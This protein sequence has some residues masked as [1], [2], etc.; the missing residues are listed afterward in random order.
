MAARACTWRRRRSS[1]GLASP[2]RITQLGGAGPWRRAGDGQR[3]KTGRRDLF[4]TLLKPR[5]FFLQ[6]YQLTT[7]TTCF[8]G[9]REYKITV[10]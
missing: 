8:S 3:K 10:E 4:E 7:P 5:G 9:R 1:A 2:W 6:N